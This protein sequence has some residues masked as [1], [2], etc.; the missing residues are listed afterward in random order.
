MSSSSGD[1]DTP[2]LNSLSPT[3]KNSKK[4]GSSNINR[5]LRNSEF[6]D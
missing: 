6:L 2:N 3:R 4:L 5:Q 1:S